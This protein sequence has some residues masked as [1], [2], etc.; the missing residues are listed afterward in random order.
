ML[1]RPSSNRPLQLLS[2]PSQTSGVPYG[3]IVPPIAPWHWIVPLMQWLVPATHSPTSVPHFVPPPG[4]PSSVVPLQ[5]LSLPSQISNDG[6]FVQPM[7][8]VV[9][10]P[11][12]HVS[13]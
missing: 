12:T 2:L 4:S 13:P 7:W 8:S 1:V 6:F 3:G 10:S 5:L 11:A 9:M